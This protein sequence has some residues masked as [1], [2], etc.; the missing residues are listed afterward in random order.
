MVRIAQPDDAYSNL[1]KRLKQTLDPNRILAPGRYD[2]EPAADS[3]ADHRATPT[4]RH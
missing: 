4:F 1:I 2:E 3:L